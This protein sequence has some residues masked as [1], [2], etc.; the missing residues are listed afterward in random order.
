MM[1]PED[2]AAAVVF[3]LTRPRTL[4]VGE[5]AFQPMSERSWG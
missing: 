5:L 2:V 3:V 1:S 4:R